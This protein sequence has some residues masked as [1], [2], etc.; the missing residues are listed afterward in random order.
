MRG[1]A[2]GHSHAPLQTGAA[3]PPAPAKGY[4]KGGAPQK[5]FT[6][7]PALQVSVPCP[8]CPPC[9]LPHRAA[10]QAFGGGLWC[11]V[12]VVL[13]VSVLSHVRRVPVCRRA[14]PPPRDHISVQA[15]VDGRVRDTTPPQLLLKG[16]QTTHKTCPATD[17]TDLRAPSPSEPF[18]TN[19]AMQN[20]G[21]AAANCPHPRPTTTDSHHSVRHEP[22]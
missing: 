22:L 5:A 14:P 10:P 21:A 1:T 18:D 7:S 11:H 4:A 19:S 17:P 8:Q 3:P 2:Q 13:W 15:T 12:C 16:G 6:K 20:A 9:V